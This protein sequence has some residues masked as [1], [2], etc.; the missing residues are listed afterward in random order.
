[1]RKYCVLGGILLAAIA[2]IDLASAQNPPSNPVIVKKDAALDALISAD[3][4]LEKL[5]GGFGFTEGALWVPKGEGGYLLFADM[6]ANVIY[7]RTPDGQLSIFMEKC[8]Y[9]QPDI[10]RVGFMQTNGKKRDDPA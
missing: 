7:Q 9:Q 3:A 2:T 10:W 4:K 1:M 5:A 6:P 8:G